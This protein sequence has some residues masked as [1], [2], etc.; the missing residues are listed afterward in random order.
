MIIPHKGGKYRAISGRYF[1]INP[2]KY[3]GGK[4]LMYKSS[5]EYKMML[6]CDKN[7]N[8]LQ[9]NYENIRLPYKDKNTGETK[10]YYIDFEIL[11][12]TNKGP[13]KIWVEVKSYC[14][15][16]PPK[17]KKNIKN[18]QIYLKNLSKWETAE[19]EAK[20]RGIEFKI[21]TENELK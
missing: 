10:H 1:P 16:I 19:K 12:N 4:F 17:N 5:L 6:Y 13:K 14:E 20:A 7:P 2:E 8:I 11:A 15:T 3:T 21:I 18:Q 9:W